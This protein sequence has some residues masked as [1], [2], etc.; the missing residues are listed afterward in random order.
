[1]NIKKLILGVNY[2]D[3]CKCTFPHTS[4]QMKFQP[5]SVANILRNHQHILT[6][7]LQNLIL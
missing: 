6:A 4:I 3:H 7:D 2:K 5:Y 1:M